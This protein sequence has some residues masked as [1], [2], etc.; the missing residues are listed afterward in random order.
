[1]LRFRT[2][3]LNSWTP[4]YCVRV[5]LERKMNEPSEEKMAY[6]HTERGFVKI[7][8][9]NKKIEY[10]ICINVSGMHHIR[11]ARLYFIV[12][13]SCSPIFQLSLHNRHYN[14][15]FI[16]H[17]RLVGS[18][19]TLIG[20]L[21]LSENEQKTNW[22]FLL[23]GI[24]DATIHRIISIHRNESNNKITLRHLAFEAFCIWFVMHSHRFGRYFFFSFY[25]V[26]IHF[27]HFSVGKPAIAITIN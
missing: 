13:A 21:K 19:A 3:K 17:T 1:M 26:R 18:W 2:Y 7:K 22:K 16:H 5:E 27:V 11:F 6:T 4:F 14:L 15:P 25:A 9:Q 8:Q 10:L 23:D 12:C 24:G 20:S